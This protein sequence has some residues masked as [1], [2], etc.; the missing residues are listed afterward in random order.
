MQNAVSNTTRDVAVLRRMRGSDWRAPTEVWAVVEWLCAPERL[1][2]VLRAALRGYP[3][4]D[5]AEDAVGDHV[6]KVA[7]R[8]YATFKPWLVG[9]AIASADIVDA[10]GLRTK[11]TNTEVGR[12]IAPGAGVTDEDS[13]PGPAASHLAQQL[14]LAVNGA[15]L[16]EGKAF[17]NADLSPGAHAFLSSLRQAADKD[18]TYSHLNRWLVEA[19]L[20]GHVRERCPFLSWFKTG[21]VRRAWD[22]RERDGRM[23]NLP[24]GRPAPADGDQIEET[25][26]AAIRQLTPSQKVLLAMRSDRIDGA[27]LWAQAESAVADL[28]TV[29]RRKVVGARL[30]GLSAAAAAARLGTTENNV[31]V[32]WHWAKKKIERAAWVETR[33]AHKWSLAAPYRQAIEAVIEGDPGTAAKDL[34]VPRELIEIRCDRGW[35]ELI[36]LW[37]SG[38]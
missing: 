1:D 18:L 23:G 10:Q 38:E 32:T 17:A 3:T 21:V 29:R 12:R 13:D 24:P 2:A 30:L 15:F 33:D 8:A 37:L 7:E 20:V 31:Y 26:R 19:A 27:D 14:T 36:A 34:G 22:L 5:R 4:P 9:M 11:L 25:L 35:Q 6:V 28:L 16:Y